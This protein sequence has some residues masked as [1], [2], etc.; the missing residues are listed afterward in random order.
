MY[1][2]GGILIEIMKEFCCHLLLPTSKVDVFQPI[3]LIIKLL[4]S[5][6]KKQMV[7]DFFKIPI[8]T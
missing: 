8:H 3:E 7:A 5:C 2:I 1:L 6:R 4:N